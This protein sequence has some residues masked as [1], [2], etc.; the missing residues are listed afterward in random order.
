MC[1]ETAVHKFPNLEQLVV[2]VQSC[3]IR[4]FHRART[5]CTHRYEVGLGF[6]KLHGH[7]C[8]NVAPHTSVPGAQLSGRLAFDSLPLSF[9]IPCYR[10]FLWTIRRAS[11]PLALRHTS[12]SVHPPPN[13]TYPFMHG[14]MPDRG[15]KDRSPLPTS[16][17]TRVHRR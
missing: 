11:A 9:P 4:A 17:A 1:D 6:I 7:E 15:S 13:R 5:A 16:S 3:R 10:Y 2:V 12:Q 14:H 8:R